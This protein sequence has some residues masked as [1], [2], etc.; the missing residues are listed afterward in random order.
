MH[1]VSKNTATLK[2]GLA[3]NQRHWEMT[4][5]DRKHMTSNSY[6]VTLA[7]NCTVSEI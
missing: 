2:S 6:I 3:V 4:P 7:L 5:F 1:L